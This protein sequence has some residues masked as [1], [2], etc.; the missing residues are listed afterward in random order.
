MKTLVDVLITFFGFHKTHAEN[1]SRRIGLL[2][3]VDP[4]IPY[5]QM[6]IFFAFL[7]CRNIIIPSGLKSDQF[8]VYWEEVRPNVRIEANKIMGCHPVSA[9][10]II[11]ITRIL[12]TARV[13]GSD[14]FWT[15][16]KLY[17]YISDTKDVP[18][19]VFD[20][21]F[22][23]LSNFEAGAFQSN[24]GI[25]TQKMGLID[26]IN[27]KLDEI[28]YSDQAEA[29][30]VKTLTDEARAIVVNNI[31]TTIMTHSGIRSL[32]FNGNISNIRFPSDD[33][34]IRVFAH[35]VVFEPVLKKDFIQALIEV[36]FGGKAE[37]IP[38]P[39]APG[40]EMIRYF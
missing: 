35:E 30:D 17:R 34:Q 25:I 38:E 7:L 21:L 13:Q 6:N 39:E 20:T 5:A 27:E 8:D 19:F 33:E 23:C 12:L 36:M 11:R 18:M 3:S 4:G 32:A 29:K 14:N 16:D 26:K 9:D 22:G 10:Q 15:L 31:A 1:V 24:D 28:K 40:L 2:N 37:S